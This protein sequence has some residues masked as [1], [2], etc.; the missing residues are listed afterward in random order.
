MLSISRNLYSLYFAHSFLLLMSLKSFL[1][2]S[3]W[4]SV[5]ILSWTLIHF[6]GCNVFP[7][8]WLLMTCTGLPNI[9]QLWHC[10]P[11]LRKNP[12]PQWTYR[13]WILFH[14]FFSHFPFLF[15]LYSFL[16]SHPLSFNYIFCVKE[17]KSAFLHSFILQHWCQNLNFLL[18]PSHLMCLWLAKLNTSEVKFNLL[19][20]NHVFLFL[21]LLSFHLWPSCPTLSV[22]S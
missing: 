21:F 20:S 16:N 13:I 2:I 1:H 3:T 17:Y 22:M 12:F 14:S 5:P 11:A 7:P 8:H 6:S 9:T 4:I 10:S 15:C 18:N 19:P